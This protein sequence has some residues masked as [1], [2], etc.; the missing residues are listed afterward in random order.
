MCGPQLKEE[1]ERLEEEEGETRKKMKATREHTKKWEE[2]RENRVRHMALQRT[3]QFAGTTQT[4]RSS[5]VSPVYLWLAGGHM[6]KLCRQK[7]EGEEGNKHLPQACSVAMS[8]L[9][10]S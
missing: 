2:T 1:T 3:A 7:G 5:Q 8:W 9:P 6:A 4:C 10:M